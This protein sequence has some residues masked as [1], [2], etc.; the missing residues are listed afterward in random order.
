MS[1]WTS[2]ALGMSKNRPGAHELL[3][4]SGMRVP[5]ARMTSASRASRL[6][7]GVPTVPVKPADRGCSSLMAP[8][9]LMVV[10]TGICVYSARAVSSAVASLSRVPLPA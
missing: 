9:P 3:S 7:T 8:W 1:T 6:A 10:A 5:M 4:I 2:L